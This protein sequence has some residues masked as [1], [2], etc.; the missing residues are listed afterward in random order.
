MSTAH[1]SAAYLAVLASALLGSVSLL[2]FLLFLLGGLP[3][4]IELRL[5]TV[6][7]L[8]WDF[9]LSMAFFMQHS[10]MVRRPFRDWI[11]RFVSEQYN[12]A[13]YSIASSIVL[14]AVI[15]LWQ[16]TPALV[17]P[18]LGARSCAYLLCALAMA[19]FVWGVNALGTFDPFGIRAVVDE[20]HGRTVAPVPFVVRGPYRWVRH[21]LYS[22]MIVL[23]WSTAE[24]RWDRLTMNVAWTLWMILGSVLEERDLVSE[25]G[26]TYQAYMREVPM[27]FPGLR[28]RRKQRSAR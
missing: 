11:K 25:F 18:S 5:T 17:E 10:G 12:G 8:W 2:G 21:P 14:L 24:I 16:E 4:L 19:V 20:L 26:S 7:A 13:I 15:L 28:A 22:V 6:Q 23:L 1:K 3:Q 27:L 9:G